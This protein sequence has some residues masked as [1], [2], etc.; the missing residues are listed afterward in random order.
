MP[1]SSVADKIKL[2][3]KMWKYQDTSHVV[4]NGDYLLC[5]IPDYPHCLHCLHCLHHDYVHQHRAVME[6]YLERY[7]DEDEHVH[8]IDEN[9]YNNDI[10]NLE[11]VYK[12]A[13]RKFH[14]R[15]RGSV[16]VDLKCPW[17]EK[18]FTRPRN[19]TLLCNQD[20]L[21]TSCCRSC[22]VKFNHYLDENG[23]NRW[24]LS[25]IYSNIVRVYYKYLDD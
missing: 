1:H 7:L 16:Y 11:L 2:S 10:N 5:K 19:H 13:H 21:T 23:L 25:R 17:C 12:D 18:L 8:H 20:A 4:K 3:I 14:L 24:A 22:S 9:K 6:N 15:N